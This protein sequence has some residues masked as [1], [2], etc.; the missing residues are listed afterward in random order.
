MAPEPLR[1]RLLP[2]RPPV[3][4]RTVQR[5]PSRSAL[6]M[7][8]AATFALL[9]AGCSTAAASAG[10]GGAKMLGRWTGEAASATSGIPYTLQVT[11][12]HGSAFAGTLST[13]ATHVPATGEVRGNSVSIRG[14]GN[15]RWQCTLAGTACR[16]SFDRG[17][18]H[19]T[20]K[21]TR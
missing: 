15:L 10:A 8:S 21:L 4:P 6:A 16:G 5:N 9:L 1:L 7:V 12:A 3:Y 18:V 19:W 2:S 11:T 14:P 20:L 13:V 17:G